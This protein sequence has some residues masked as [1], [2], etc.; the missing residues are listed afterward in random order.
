[1]GLKYLYQAGD[2]RTIA[3]FYDMLLS[4]IMSWSGWGLSEQITKSG[5]LSNETD[6]GPAIDVTATLILDE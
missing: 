3:F 5:Y 6:P 2:F 4:P 1:M